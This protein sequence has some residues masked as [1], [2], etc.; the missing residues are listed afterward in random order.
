MDY[1]N[2]GE[3]LNIHDNER[4]APGIKE[5][6]SWI[7]EATGFAHGLGRCTSTGKAESSYTAFRGENLLSWATI[8]VEQKSVER[9]LCDFCVYKAINYAIRRGELSTPPSADWY[10]K[11]TFQFPKMPEVDELKAAMSQRMFMKNGSIDFSAILGP[12]WKDKFGEYHKQI[13][14][15]RELGL[16]LAIFETVSGSLISENLDEQN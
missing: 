1:L 9:R 11:V 16:P 5:F 14:E 4:P 10:K 8:Y 6:S 12:D 13:E 15:A 2:P 7:Q 3:K